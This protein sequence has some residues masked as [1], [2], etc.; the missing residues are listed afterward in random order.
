MGARPKSKGI[1]CGPLC[2][3][4]GRVQPALEIRL[5]RGVRSLPIAAAKLTAGSDGKETKW[6][7]AL[8]RKPRSAPPCTKCFS[9]AGQDGYNHCKSQC[10]FG[11]WCSERCLGCTGKHDAKTEACVGAD[12][13]VPKPDLC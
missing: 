7:S 6:R 12:V 13:D 3:A 2:T 1:A 8:G 11:D 5:F 9:K 4:A 10:L